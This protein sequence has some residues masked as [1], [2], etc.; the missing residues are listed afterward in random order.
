MALPHPY[1]IIWTG[2]L[3][4]GD[5]V[6]V[7]MD[8]QFVGL[9]VQLPITITYTPGGDVSF[10]LMTTDVEIYSG[11][12]HAVYWDWSP[13]QKLPTPVGRIDDTAPIPGRPEYHMVTVPA[14]RGT[15]GKHTLTIHI[16]PNLSE[17]MRD[18]FVLKRIEMSDDIGAKIGW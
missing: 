9:L 17:G 15:Q 1:Y 4:L 11:K 2:S 14:D 13:G 3:N 5:T 10:L 16:N 12:N 6:G 8:S 18:D 7:F